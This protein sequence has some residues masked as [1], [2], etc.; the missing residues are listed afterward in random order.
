MKTL[1]PQMSYGVHHELREHSGS[2]GKTKGECLELEV[3]VIYAK[4]K[5]SAV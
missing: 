3:F 2:C 1:L 5:K 4:A